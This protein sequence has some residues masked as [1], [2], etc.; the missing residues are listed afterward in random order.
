MKSDQAYKLWY[1]YLVESDKKKWT[2]EVQEDFSDVLTKSFDDWFWDAYF[3]LWTPSKAHSAPVREYSSKDVVTIAESEIVVV[4]DLDR[5]KESLLRSLDWLIGMK[6]KPRAAGRPPFVQLPNVKYPFARR[7]DISS[8]EI[9]LA[10]Y[11]LKKTGI[12]NWE[13]GNELA[14]EFPVL[15]DQR[16]KEDDLDVVQKKKILESAVSRYLKLAEA[17]L[18]GVTKGIFPAK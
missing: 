18:D 14:K 17:V 13:V 8:L 11:K 1:E 4:I 9:A 10:A 6:Q 12:A 3:K 5:P 16:I 15:Q 2:D 7:P